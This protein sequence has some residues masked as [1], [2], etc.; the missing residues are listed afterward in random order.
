MF[1][2]G[3]ASEVESEMI[4][5]WVNHRRGESPDADAYWIVY[6]RSGACAAKSASNARMA[7]SLFPVIR[8]PCRSG[9]AV[10]VAARELAASGGGVTETAR[11][12]VRRFVRVIL[13]RA[14]PILPTIS[15]DHVLDA[16]ETNGA[17]AGNAD[18]LVRVTV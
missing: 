3:E 12:A 7:L 13:A 14:S 8:F 15:G 18:V 4:I 16:F 1:G 11:R 2:G 6:A 5:G 10:S 17:N 9:S